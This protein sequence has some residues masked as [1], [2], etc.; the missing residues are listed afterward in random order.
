VTD[1][2]AKV[3][4]A[5]HIQTPSRAKKTEEILARNFGQT[6]CLTKRERDVKRQAAVHKDGLEGVLRFAERRV[7]RNDET[8]VVLRLGTRVSEDEDE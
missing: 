4:L 1:S 6:F 5:S 8:G 3:L 2:S 7:A